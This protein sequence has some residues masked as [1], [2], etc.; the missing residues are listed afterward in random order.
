MKYEPYNYALGIKAAD[1]SHNSLFLAVG[2]FDEKIRL[3]NAITW[4]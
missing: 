2:S 4:Q 3:L 1:F